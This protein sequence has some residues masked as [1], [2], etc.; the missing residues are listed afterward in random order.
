M[1]NIKED[2][3]V[4]INLVTFVALWIILLHFSKSGLTIDSEA[5]KKLP[6]VV[7]AYVLLR[8][9]FTKWGWRIR[10]LRGWLVPYPDLEG[11]WQGTL[12]STWVDPSGSS[13]APIP[14][15]IVI[16]QTFDSISVL[17]FTAESESY[18]TTAQINEDDHSGVM[19]LTYNYTN[20]SK[21]D[22]RDRSP[23]HDGA[24]NLRIVESSRLALEGAYW[25]SRKTTG[26][27]AVNLVS[28]KRANSFDEGSAIA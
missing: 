11:T 12:K 15:V 27:I 17:M 28:R 5:L 25:T 19:R 22:V 1:K 6:D 26:E 4:W 20:R 16:R 13:P 3:L 23:M 21:A 24:T 18:S 14:A 8:F 2:L 9:I 7:T 10:F